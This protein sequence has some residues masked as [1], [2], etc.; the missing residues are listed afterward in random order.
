MTSK[1]KVANPAAPQ[2]DELAQPTLASAPESIET[3]ARLTQAQ[4]RQ[5]AERKILDAAL[6]IVARRGSVRMTLSEV[7]EAAGYSRGL[8]AHRFGNKEGLLKELVNTISERFTARS[9]TLPQRQPGLDTLRGQ[10]T[11]YFERDDQR[12]IE[13]RA[14]LV[15]MTEGFME[16]SY[17]NPH[18]GEYLRSTIERFAEQIL[19][20]IEQG[21]I[22]PDIDP[23][24]AAT[25]ILGAMRGILHQRLVFN[26]LDLSSLRNITMQMVER[27]LGLDL[28]QLT[29]VQA[30]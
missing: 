4:R 11:A 24:T 13:T 25:L 23:T 1:Q 19:Y 8:P 22:R 9:S 7:G 3:P 5:L 28:G 30:E 27:T 2:H 20:G 15:M 16:D 18:I 6:E 29:P 21:E 17:L 12:W 14:L 26:D 10:V